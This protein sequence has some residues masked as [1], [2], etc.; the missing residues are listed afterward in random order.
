MITPVDITDID[1]C[2]N[3]NIRNRV[4]L[5]LHEYICS[6]YMIDYHQFNA[7]K[8]TKAYRRYIEIR[9]IINQ[10]LY[11]NRLLNMVGYELHKKGL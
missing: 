11:K 4:Q 5:H 3:T 1:H 9:T 2:L 6:G 7:M 8:K 10:S